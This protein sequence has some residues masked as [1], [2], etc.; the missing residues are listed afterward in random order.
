MALPPG[1]HRPRLAL[2]ASWRAVPVAAVLIWI[3]LYYKR[4]SRKVKQGQVKYVRARPP[5]RGGGALGFQRDCVPLAVGPEGAA[6]RTY[7]HRNLGQYRIENACADEMN[8][9]QMV[10]AD[11]DSVASLRR[12]ICMCEMAGMQPSA[13]VGFVRYC[14]NFLAE[15]PGEIRLQELIRRRAGKHALW[16]NP[17]APSE[18]AL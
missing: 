17:K 16:A 11:F 9:R 15:I 2:G 7:R 1:S 10:L 14:L 3:Y 5:P 6:L 13:R 8:F 18:P 4:E 12:E